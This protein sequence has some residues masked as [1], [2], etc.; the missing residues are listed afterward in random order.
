[1]QRSAAKDGSLG[2]CGA[3]GPHYPYGENG[4]RTRPEVPRGASSDRPLSE[5]TKVRRLRT[6]AKN[7]QCAT[8]PTK[9]NCHEIVTKLQRPKLSRI[10]ASIATELREYAY[11]LL[12]TMASPSSVNCIATAVETLVGVFVSQTKY[13]HLHRGESLMWTSSGPDYA[14]Q[15]WSDGYHAT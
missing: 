13:W 12:R 1:M 8:M 14:H 15:A 10:A 6:V 7:T 9:R 11:A 2:K 3:N 4:T 5:D